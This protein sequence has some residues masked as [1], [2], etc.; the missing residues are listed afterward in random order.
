MDSTGGDVWFSGLNVVLHD[1]WL[2][3]ELFRSLA[4]PTTALVLQM[5][6][7][8]VA[9]V[10][11]A[12]HASW[13]FKTRRSLQSSA[14]TALLIGSTTQSVCVL[15]S[16]A[17]GVARA[18]NIS[19]AQVAGGATSYPWFFEFLFPL[20]RGCLVNLVACFVA[21]VSVMF[22]VRGSSRDRGG[23]RC[24]PLR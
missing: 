19:I 3:R 9:L 8:L 20:I 12:I 11:V 16:V 6:L 10:G 2:R 4:E 23:H 22:S 7:P 24:Q 18:A 14:W 13:R 15:I 1:S 17:E 5:V 21:A